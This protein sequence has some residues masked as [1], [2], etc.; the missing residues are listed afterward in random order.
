[1]LRAALGLAISAACLYVFFRDV[2]AGAL[3]SSLADVN[4]LLLVPA[5]AVYFA[6]VWLRAARWQRLVQ[7]FARVPTARLFRVIVI[8]FAVNNVLPLR[9]GELVRTFLLRQSHGVPLTATLA[10]ILF[11]RL[12]DLVVLCALLTAVSI[13]VPL[14]GWLSGL[15]TVARGVTAGASAGAA[16]LLLA[17]PALV[18]WLL[19]LAARAADRL[20]ARLGRLVRSFLAGLR[21]VE[22][23]GAMISVGALSVACWLAELGLYYFVMLA[24]GFD[25]GLSSLLAGMVAANLATALP[26]SPGYV[27]TFDVPLQSV[28]GDTFGVATAV[29]SSYTL[30]AHAVLLVPVVVL[31]AALLGRERLSLRALSRGRVEPRRAARGITRWSRE[32]LPNEPRRS[33]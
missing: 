8:G 32:A 9:L 31:G 29:A 16:V 7:P 1:M 30:V 19:E 14:D 10:S 20:S 4:L 23:P 21:A 24:C 22:T 6:G 15:A 18:R 11:E 12:L 33:V 26:S 3:A 17:P 2:D 27:G 28:L 13:F 25:S 5:V